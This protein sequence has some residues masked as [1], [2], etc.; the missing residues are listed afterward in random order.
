MS[1]M[2]GAAMLLASGVSAQNVLVN[3]D[4][5]ASPPSV[6]G[7]N[8]GW[9]VAPWVVGTGNQPNVV[10]VDG[11]G[12]YNYGT[13]GPESD[14]SAPGAGIP[15]HYLDVSGGENDFYQ[16]FTPRCGGD[17]EFGGSFSTRANLAGTG[18]VAIR[19]GTGT[20][21]AL[22]G[23]TNV[24]SLPPGNSKTDPWKNVSFTVPVTAGTTYSFVV[25]MDN[26]VNFDNAFV[27]YKIKCAPET[28][29][30]AKIKEAICDRNGTFT[31]ST[32]VT[33]N[34]GHPV[35]YVL[36][37]PPPG[38]TYS[39]S[40]NVVPVTLGNGQSAAVTVTVTGATP[41]QQICLN[42][43][44]QDAEGRT[45]C[46]IRECF[47]LPDCACLRILDPK[48]GCD[49]GPATY[50]YTFTAQNFTG[51]TIQQLFVIPSVGSVTPQLIATNLASG[52]TAQV[53]LHLSGVSAGQTVCF[54]LTAYGENLKECCT[55]RVCVKLPLIQMQCD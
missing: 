11:P 5:E 9:S 8:I 30:S 25:T 45:C 18:S 4:F 26:N 16:S 47:E 20:T 48:V 23:T 55:I 6:N 37:A 49:P 42:Y 31:V 46:S 15:Q 21:G 51:G 50:A 1:A 19:L 13:S 3:G 14:A 2:L 27:T 24:V 44:L 53:T 32:Q 10:Q 41:G 43:L 35:Q 12:G 34:S 28:C 7:N 39:V 52:G 33:N 22:V 54:L 38:A 36:I 40:P 17:V 29:M